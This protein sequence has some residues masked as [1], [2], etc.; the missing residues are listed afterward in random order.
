MAKYHSHAIQAAYFN[1][2]DGNFIMNVQGANAFAVDLGLGDESTYPNLVSYYT[3][4]GCF[5][6]GIFGTDILTRVLLERG[7]AELAVKLLTGDGA[8][9]FEKWRKG[10]ATT[11]HE[12]WDSERSRSHNHHMFGAPVAYFFEYLLG[13]RQAD[14]SAGYRSLVIEPLTV[15]SVGRMS[16]SM[17]TP[18]G[19]VAVSYEKNAEKINF[20]VLI[21]ENTEAIFKYSGKELALKSGKNELHFNNAENN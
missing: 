19:E 3:K 1:S 21:P 20:T 18:Q 14:D 5:D 11:F 8:Q 2:F 17:K 13:I 15:S 9:G 6:T 10:G 4:L 7:D 16:G 12:Y